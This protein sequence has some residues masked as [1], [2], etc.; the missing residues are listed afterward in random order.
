LLRPA[1]AGLPTIS[2][3]VRLRRSDARNGPA[4]KTTKP[5]SQGLMNR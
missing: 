5:I 2:Q 4:V 1:H 3:F